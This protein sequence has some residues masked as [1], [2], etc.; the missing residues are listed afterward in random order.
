MNR[1]V[2]N[3]KL[4][5][6]DGPNGVGKTTIIQELK[7]ELEKREIDT[8]FTK[9]PTGN[10]LGCFVREYAEKSKG[11]SI[12]C[13]VAADRYQ[14]LQDE[15]IPQ[16]EK[17][18]I[19]ITD[20][21]ILS[22]LILQRMDEVSEEF[23]MELNNEIIQPDLQIAVFADSQIIQSRLKERDSL[24]RFEKDNKTNIELKYMERGIQ[25]LQEKG[26]NVFKL[27]NDDDLKG[28]VFRVIQE[29][30]NL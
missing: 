23:I 12:A 17:G 30:I 24:T 20:R 2:Y 27:V 3:G 26:I 5:A 22:S 21:Y 7:K 11:I 25:I 1:N 28:N 14:H 18:K 13:L 29:I 19:V 15:I 4:V 6:I 16:L 8:Y 9:E 10:E